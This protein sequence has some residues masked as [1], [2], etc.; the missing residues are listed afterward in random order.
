MSTGGGTLRHR[1]GEGDRLLERTR[2]APRARAATDPLRAAQGVILGIAWGAAF[3]LAL[4]CAAFL[5]R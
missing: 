1:T 2:L 5:T 3:W 4:A